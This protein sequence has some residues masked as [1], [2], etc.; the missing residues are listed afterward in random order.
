[1]T[2]VFLDSF[3]GGAADLKKAQRNRDNVLGALDKDPRVS[4]FDLSEHHWLWSLIVELKT[5][6]L[7]NEVT[8]PYPWN[9]YEITE[10]GRKVLEQQ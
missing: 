9:R 6:G 10:A 8:E 1:M 5:A 3:S 7:I 2:R 4:C